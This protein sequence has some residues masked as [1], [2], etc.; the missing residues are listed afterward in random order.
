LIFPIATG[1][2]IYR[3]RYINNEKSLLFTN[4][5]LDIR[6]SHP[7]I[8]NWLLKFETDLINRGDKGKNWWNLRSCDY[9]NKIT[10]PKI[11][12]RSISNECGFYL[13]EKGDL[14]LSNNNYFIASEN[15]TLLG[16]L[17]SKLSFLFLSNLCTS[18]QGGFFD[19]RRDKVLQVP[20][21]KNIDSIDSDIGKF[22]KL[23][24]INNTI[25]LDSTAK[26]IRTLQRKF[27]GLIISKKIETWYG[28]NFAEFL[29]ELGKKKINLSIKEEAE[30]EDYFA[31]ES[32]KVLELQS[33]IDQTDKEIDRLV[34]ELYG[35]TEEEIKIIENA[36]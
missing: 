23:Q 21:P 9:Y 20:I 32:Q 33:Q 3:Y 6:F 28:L 24:Q 15:Y 10:K 34:Y 8:Y 31:L 26:F 18:L 11:I 22:A 19:F 17:N 35:L 30:W 29:K 1:K 25:I 5:D 7:E 4:Y 13:D 12:W 27:E 16:L 36:I 2:E 14:L